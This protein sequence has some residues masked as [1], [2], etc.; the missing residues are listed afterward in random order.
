VENA[1]G[2]DSRLVN[3]TVFE[4]KTRSELITNGTKAIRGYDPKTG[5]ELWRLTPN[6]EIT[7]PTPFVRMI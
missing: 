4:G 7:T 6:S 5:L 3:P 2:R 1:T